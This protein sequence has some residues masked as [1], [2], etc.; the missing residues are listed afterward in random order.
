MYVHRSI[1]QTY[2]HA[3]PPSHQFSFYFSII[4]YINIL[5]IRIKFRRKIQP[6]FY[7]ATLQYYYN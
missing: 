4:L 6:T 3:I 2:H 7:L 5:C 1:S